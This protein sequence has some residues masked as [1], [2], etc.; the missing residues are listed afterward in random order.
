MAA[1]AHAVVCPHCQGRLFR[2]EKIVQIDASVVVRPDLPVPA[3]TVQ[4]MYR[5][6]CL[7]CGQ[8]LEQ[9]WSGRHEEASGA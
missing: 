8:V 2:E 3:R 5:Y 6:V 4:E 7:Q 1:N 9:T